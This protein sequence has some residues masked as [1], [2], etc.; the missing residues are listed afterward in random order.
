MVM[1]ILQ[2]N[3]MQSNMDM[4]L[5]YLSRDRILESANMIIQLF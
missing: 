2:H 4:S 1:K 5:E 3:L